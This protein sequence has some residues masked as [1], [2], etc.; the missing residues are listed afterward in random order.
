MSEIPNPSMG[1][2]NMQRAMVD[3]D[4]K[5][6]TGLM[7]TLGRSVVGVPAAI[8][9]TLGTSLRLIGDESVNNFFDSI[10][11]T[12]QA[13]FQR[14][15]SG[16]LHFVGDIAGSLIPGALGIRAFRG[17]SAAL[18]TTKVGETYAGRILLANKAKESTALTALRQ[19]AL[20]ATKDTGIFAKAIDQALVA[21]AK[22]NFRN[23]F[24][25]NAVRD[26]VAFDVA[27]IGAMN[28]ST[29]IF[30]EDPGVSDYL[31]TVALGIGI[32][33]TI[34]GV[35]QRAVARRVEIKAFDDFRKGTGN[36]GSLSDIDPYDAGSLFARGAHPGAALPVI[37]ETVN[38]LEKLKAEILQ[39]ADSQKL[40]SIVQDIRQF[41][42]LAQE[43]I[44]KLTRP[45]KEL[46]DLNPGIKHPNLSNEQLVT[47][48]ELNKQRP[49]L[50]AGANKIY[51]KDDFNDIVWA[52]AIYE[53]EL[54]LKPKLEKD[55]TNPKL[56]EEQRQLQLAKSQSIQIVNAAGDVTPS[57]TT[58]YRATQK[59]VTTKTIKSSGDTFM[60]S[61]G[62]KNI[63]T[64]DLKV[65]F[66]E[67]L[68]NGPGLVE[69]SNM[70]AT[71]VGA[72]DNLIKN[73]DTYAAGSIKYD[74]KGHFLSDDLFIK[75]YETVS[76][77]FGTAKADSI[78]SFPKRMNK[79]KIQ[80]T[81]LEKKYGEF[82]KLYTAADK[83]GERF[84]I[85]D[86]THMLNLPTAFPGTA[87]P[88]VELFVSKAADG[89]SKSLFK[90][91][92]SDETFAGLQSL[93]DGLNKNFSTDIVKEKTFDLTGNGLN[94]LSFD[95]SLVKPTFPDLV[96]IRDPIPISD[97]KIERMQQLAAGRKA[98]NLE[99]MSAFV[100]ASAATGGGVISNT[101][102][103][104]LKTIGTGASE[105]LSRSAHEIS[106]AV[107]ELNPAMLPSVG[108]ITP[109][110]NITRF[111]PVLKTVAEIAALA[112]KATKTTMKEIIAPHLPA[113][114]ALRSDPLSM[115]DFNLFHHAYEFGFD[116]SGEVKEVAKDRFGYLL[117][118]TKRNRD[119]IM[120][121]F[122]DDVDRQYAKLKA[123]ELLLPSMVNG[124]NI[125]KP[126][127]VSKVAS[128]AIDGLSALTVS[129][130]VERNAFAK[131]AGEQ[132]TQLR[133][134]HIASPAFEN[135]A[136]EFTYDSVKGKIIGTHI[137]V[138]GKAAKEAAE[139]AAKGK[140]G[141]ITLS[142]KDIQ[143]NAK[144]YDQATDAFSAYG[145]TSVAISGR[146]AKSTV[147][148]GNQTFDAITDQLERGML[149]DG[150]RAREFFY[151]DQIKY[152]ELAEIATG[153][154]NNNWRTV[155][156][157]NVF[158]LYRK[159]IS[160][161][162]LLQPNTATGQ[163]ARKFENVADAGLAYMHDKLYNLISLSEEKGIP[164]LI[165]QYAE[166]RASH[167]PFESAIEFAESIHNIKTPPEIRKISAGLAS[168]TN[169]MILR[170]YDVAQPMIN[171]V[172]LA[173]TMPAV[174]SALRYQ[175]ELHGSR[176]DWLEANGLFGVELGPNFNYQMPSPTKMLASSFHSLWTNK[177]SD[178]LAKAEKL[179][180][181]SLNIAEF[182]EAIGDLES[183]T[184][185]GGIGKAYDKFL[186]AG[187][188]L[189]DHSDVFSRKV[190]II[191]GID[192]AQKVFKLK[193]DTAIL[194]FANKHANDIVGD[195]RPINKP[196]IFQGAAGISLGLFQTY[197]FNYFRRVFSY[198]ENKD[199]RSVVTQYA[200]QAAVFGGESVPGFKQFNEHFYA[201][202]YG[203]GNFVDTVSKRFGS[204]GAE[205][206]LQ[207]TVSNLPKLFGLDG[208]SLASRGDANIRN[209]P[210]SS[211]EN[212]PSFSMMK[213]TLAGIGELAGQFRE[214]GQPSLQRSAE[215]VANY[216]VNR[217]IS[218][219]I[220]SI[221][222]ESTDRL[223]QIAEDDIRNPM[224]VIARLLSLRTTH[225]TAVREAYYTNKNIQAA[226]DEAA[227]RARLSLRAKARA[228]T[229]DKE[230][231][232]QALSDYVK[233]GGDSANFVD[234]LVETQRI[235]TTSRNRLALEDA[236]SREDWDQL[237]RLMLA[238]GNK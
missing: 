223:G 215:I 214:G 115:V 202:D 84:P 109:V 89:V 73:I 101:L 3:V 118:D 225:E 79:R 127:T 93:M 68:G 144:L 30:G 75:A 8:V 106:T 126:V 35:V 17:V 92:L 185:K 216:S 143:Q 98:L 31:A 87:H 46:F 1:L 60:I 82:K 184:L 125:S 181:T 200:T 6:S 155:K 224:S 107:D 234:M 119:L 192:I 86:I 211:I 54:A 65:K 173:S 159:L 5:E 222:G 169:R 157:T 170:L 145:E 135:K 32:S 124:G 34:A 175:P 70:Q 168:V 229:L 57:I 50:F 83:A 74:P 149:R 136:V 188:Y 190:A 4:K 29:V 228:G 161:D 120:Q 10:G 77:K 97:I 123:G 40:K 111:S 142:L 78:F 52:D 110:N 15:K 154:G 25:A 14:E 128:N 16:G 80:L 63:V 171:V 226:Q 158:D 203:E 238:M 45:S 164:K 220:E 152:S 129:R 51:T 197:M 105:G 237:S 100:N 137:G 151:K 235:G 24:V 134:M 71:A 163:I 43:G 205:W 39:T 20:T 193:D 90:K 122:P 210:A 55:P 113:F 99:S 108:A 116:M 219:V 236:I 33:G 199:V 191:N 178:L 146:G 49:E 53:K 72:L 88:I 56:L 9:D 156:E 102:S 58:G 182:T 11:A 81:S 28:N 221:S 22:N 62:P 162:S 132:Q 91:E 61:G 69:L 112:D 140:T 230:S 186:A 13:D 207:G 41:D 201:E 36:G 103:V 139:A 160:G 194:L 12:D 26:S 48:R 212:L 204:S 233:R 208:I 183:K 96:V 217:P 66:D 196:Q 131:L 114:S 187:A 141:V 95:N 117:K 147:S 67:N 37:G 176:T 76:N 21:P 85:E 59:S 64:K 209:V 138:S 150:R 18:R 231:V 198:I 133:P 121:H 165:K 206:L 148:V 172:S 195:Y 227:T 166:S 23:V 94:T 232:Y 189:A 47:L 44:E 218:R 7:E 104:L 177:Y 130:G 153:A 213:N 167:N 174:N 2:I 42:V 27:V 179:G 180:M 19:E 38:H